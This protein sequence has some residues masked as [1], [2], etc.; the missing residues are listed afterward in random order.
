MVEHGV[1]IEDD[2]VVTGDGYRLLSDG[3]PR[4]VEAIEALMEGRG[5]PAVVPPR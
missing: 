1:R 5:L 3:S 2:V 4:E